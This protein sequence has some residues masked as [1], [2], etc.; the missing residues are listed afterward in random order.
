VDPVPDPMLN[1]FSNVSN[2]M[3]NF[4]FVPFTNVPFYMEDGYMDIRAILKKKKF[5]RRK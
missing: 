2:V 1:I 4:M 3:D 5:L